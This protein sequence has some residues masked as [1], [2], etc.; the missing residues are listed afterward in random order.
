MSGD[1]VRGWR[2]AAQVSGIS[3]AHLR[4]YA[5]RG[6]L[7]VTKD[8][9]G[10]CVFQKAELEHLASAPPPPVAA[11]VLAPSPTLAPA[12]ASARSLPTLNADASATDGRLAARVFADLDAGRSL[13]SIATERELTA[14]VLQRLYADW[15][16]L[17]EI[18][19]T[20]PTV[21]IAVKVLQEQNTA[22]ARQVQALAQRVQV[23]EKQA[24][25][26][27]LAGLRDHFVCDNCGT[28]RAVSA[29]V[30]CEACQTEHRLGWDAD[31]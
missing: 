1:I 22:L 20:N 19:V 5:D 25:A 14:P 24:A 29:P 6:E 8:A 13:T 15:L 12:P 16:A 26:D 18:D 28:A 7:T 10:V 3:V 17:K 23:L 11:P 31:E 9:E 27:P 4:R 30:I 2:E 21:P